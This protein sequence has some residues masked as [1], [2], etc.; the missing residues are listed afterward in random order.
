[1]LAA[2]DAAGPGDE[3]EAGTLR[4]TV[5]VGS[6]TRYVVDLDVG[7]TLTVVSQNDGGHRGTA[8]ESPG[9]RVVLAW[10]P[11]NMFTI[12]ESDREVTE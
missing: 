9:G 1:M 4:E 6:V 7:G 5:Y 10:R 12:T 3:T 11:E 2:G 8:G